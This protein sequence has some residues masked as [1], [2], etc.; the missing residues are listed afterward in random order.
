MSY[1]LSNSVRHEELRVLFFTI[2]LLPPAINS[3]DLFYE[4]DGCV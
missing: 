2:L 1:I 4:S 3:P